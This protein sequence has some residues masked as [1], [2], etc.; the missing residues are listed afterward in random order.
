MEEC[1]GVVEVGEEGRRRERRGRDAVSSP[2]KTLDRRCWREYALHFNLLQ[3]TDEMS[4]GR[5]VTE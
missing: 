3:G 4:K 2:E 1:K 5:K